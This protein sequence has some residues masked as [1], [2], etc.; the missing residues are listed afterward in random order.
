MATPPKRKISLSSQ[1]VPARGSSGKGR[2]AGLPPK[3]VVGSTARC[4][5]GNS[6]GC[7]I[8]E[9][10]ILVVSDSVLEH[11]LHPQVLKLPAPSIPLPRVPQN[12]GG[13]DSD[14]PLNTEPSEY[15]CSQHSGQL[16]ISPLTIAHCERNHPH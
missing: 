12:L 8:L 2:A 7:C 10:C 11:P 5:A 13:S 3:R 4:S 15:A 1:Q 9:G 16:R 6:H 14:V